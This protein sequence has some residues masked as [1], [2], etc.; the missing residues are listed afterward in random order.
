[1][2]INVG[3]FKL[4]VVQIVKKTNKNIHIRLKNGNIVISTPVMLNY[5][6]VISMINPIENKIISLINNKEKSEMIHYLGKEYKIDIVKSNEFNVYLTEDTLVVKTKYLNDE[7]ISKLI[8]QFYIYNMEKYVLSIFDDIFSTYKDL[9]IE[10]P[11]LVF[12]YTKSF[13][14]K[15]YPKKKYIE[16]S[17]ICMKYHPM[18]I[19]L[20][21]HHEICHFKYLG[22]QN[23]F[24]SYFEKHFPN[25]KKIQHELRS[26]KYNDKY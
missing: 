23:D 14:G 6:E 11:K 18:Y 22:H 1:M 24:Y 26:L 5:N 19:N 9:S 12:K 16:Y 3:N 7:V 25:A 21:I 20:I 4:E 8:K 15:C 13:F 17:G 10:K 2:L